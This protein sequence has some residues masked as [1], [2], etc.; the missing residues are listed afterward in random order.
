MS[1]FRDVIE[2]KRHENICEDE[3]RNISVQ[4]RA[5]YYQCSDIVD[6]CFEPTHSLNQRND[7]LPLSLCKL[8]RSVYRTN[9]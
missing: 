4:R 1:L 7:R 8:F 3:T 9:H 5:A 2:Q 6:T